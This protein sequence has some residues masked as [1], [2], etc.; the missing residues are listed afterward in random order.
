MLFFLWEE[1]AD[2]LFYFSDVLY[3]GVLEH[4]EGSGLDL[5]SLSIRQCFHYP[6]KYRE[7][8][9][10]G[11]VGLEGQGLR[12]VAFIFHDLTG[13]RRLALL[14]VYNQLGSSL[15]DRLHSVIAYDY[16]GYSD[17]EAGN[18]NPFSPSDKMEVV[19]EMNF[20]YVWHR[21]YFPFKVY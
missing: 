20:R 16:R 18:D 15:I 10:K 13:D 11:E 2:K 5:F 3:Y 17:K 21:D 19:Q 12:L 1:V 9:D 8:V 7:A 14:F 4:L 6:F